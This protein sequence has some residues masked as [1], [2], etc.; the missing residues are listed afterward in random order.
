MSKS[1]IIGLVILLFI[2]RIIFLC[3]FILAVLS[4]H[5]VAGRAW[6]DSNVLSG[7]QRRF[8]TNAEIG[9]YRF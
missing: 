8:K 5:N 2:G 1:I 4:R 3:P 7:W 6:M 9:N